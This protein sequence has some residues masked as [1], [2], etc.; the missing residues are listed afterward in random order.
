MF[1]NILVL[2]LFSLVGTSAEAKERIIITGSS[3]VAPVLS[4]LAR[5]YEKTHPDIRIDVQSGGS[6]RGIA[7]VRNNIAAVGMVSRALKEKESDLTPYTF[8]RDGLSIILNAKNPVTKLTKQQIQDIYLGKISNWKELG[9]KDAKIVIVNKAEG[10]STLELFLK[11]FALKNS[12]IKA[13]IIIGDNE[14]GI[15]TVSKN[16]N[17]IGY[18]SVGAAE[19]NRSVGVPIKLLPYEGVS[20]SVENVRNGSYSLLRDLNLV[21]SGPVLEPTKKF[22]AFVKS[23]SAKTTIKEHFFVATED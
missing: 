9:G 18:V 4:D 17:A 10:R 14:Q 16:P 19:Y 15:K 6:S 1:K 13:S 5:L 3:T 20:A 12:E 2:V 23:R 7:D 8:A 11:F 21:T 22:I